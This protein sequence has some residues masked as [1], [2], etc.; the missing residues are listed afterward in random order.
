MLVH[1][2]QVAIKSIG[3]LVKVSQLLLAWMLVQ[4]SMDGFM[5]S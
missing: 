3:K 4:A 2:T 5:A 1:I